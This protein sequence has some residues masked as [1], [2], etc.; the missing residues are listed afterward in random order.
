M[1]PFV[2]FVAG[3]PNFT[4]LRGLGGNVHTVPLGEVAAVLDMTKDFSYALMEA[5]IAYREDVDEVVEVLRESCTENAWARR[6]REFSE[7]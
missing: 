3:G 2:D 1:F 7:C 6:A 4:S 5:G